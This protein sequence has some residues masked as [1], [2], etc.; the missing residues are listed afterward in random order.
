MSTIGSNLGG[1]FDPASMMQQMKDRFK[2]ADIDGS[3]SVSKAEFT[4]AGTDNGLQSNKIEKIF[5]K[6]DS[7]SDGQ[8]SQ[9]E[10][11]A[12]LNHMQSRMESLM[13]SND[14]VANFDAVMSLM[15]VLQAGSTS[16]DTKQQI[17]ESLEKLRSAGNSEQSVNESL[18]RINNLIPQIDTWA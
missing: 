6:I 10:H 12:M 13:G 7:N 1:A 4:Q 8:I 2:T 3:G 5:A 14:S 15:E 16:K 17:E 11:E 9:Q 18:S